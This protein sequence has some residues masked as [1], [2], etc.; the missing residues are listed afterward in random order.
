[1]LHN[2]GLQVLTAHL[3]GCRRGVAQGEAY[4]PPLPLAQEP[5]RGQS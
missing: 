1:M 2:A 3:Q 5:M 4:L